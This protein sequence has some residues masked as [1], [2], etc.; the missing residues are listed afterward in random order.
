MKFSSLL[1]KERI[2]QGFS[3]YELSKKS[4]VN[5]KT[6]LD[7]ERGSSP[8][9]DTADKLCKALEIQFVIGAVV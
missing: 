4:G 3:A 1:T 6:I 8:N 7:I 5:R 2:K 9:L